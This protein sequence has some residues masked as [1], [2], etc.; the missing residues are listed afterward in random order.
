M[1]KFIETMKMAAEVP[2]LTTTLT[3]AFA[4]IVGL[5]SAHATLAIVNKASAKEKRA[6]ELHDKATNV[7]HDKTIT[8]ETCKA[9]LHDIK[10][11]L[12][13]NKMEDHV[14]Y[15]LSGKPVHFFSR[16]KVKFG[17]EKAFQDS[18]IR[19]IDA[20]IKSTETRPATKRPN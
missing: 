4:G 9:Y 2:G 18:V 6:A 5:Y 16:F 3:T 13:M 7:Y 15:G 8:D 10:I 19:D 11:Q 1:S 12:D 17:P 20:K 14:L